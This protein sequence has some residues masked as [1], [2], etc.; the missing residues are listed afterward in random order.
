LKVGMNSDQRWLTVTGGTNSAHYAWWRL[1]REKA[2]W[3]GIGFRS[4]NVK[5][6]DINMELF[7]SKQADLSAAL[8]TTVYFQDDWGPLTRRLYVVLPNDGTQP[9][10]DIARSS[11]ELMAKLIKL[12]LPSLLERGVYSV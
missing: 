10:E 2:I 1:T 4:K 11:A 3:I 8:G 12:T 7:R 6:N 9:L 5:E